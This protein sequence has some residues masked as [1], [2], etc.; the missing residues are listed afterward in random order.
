[1]DTRRRIRNYIFSSSLGVEEQYS[2]G[3][4]NPTTISIALG[5]TYRQTWWWWC[6]SRVIEVQ[7]CRSRGGRTASMDVS[8]RSRSSNQ[9]T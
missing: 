4:S 7:S 6:A 1:M 9:R 3:I 5:R 2:T 8:G